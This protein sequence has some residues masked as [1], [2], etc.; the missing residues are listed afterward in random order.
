MCVDYT[1][2][3]TIFEGSLRDTQ[4]RRCSLLY[5]VVLLALHPRLLLRILTKLV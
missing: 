5:C 3:Q 1:D 4:D 2:E